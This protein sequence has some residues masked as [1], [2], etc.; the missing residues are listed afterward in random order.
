MSVVRV[1]AVVRPAVLA[2]VLGFEA[3]VAVVVAEEGLPEGI[4]GRAQV[5]AQR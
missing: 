4:V 1:P 5:Q 2:L 3:A